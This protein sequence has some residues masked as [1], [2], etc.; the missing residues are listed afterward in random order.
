ME[1]LRDMKCIRPTFIKQI[2][3]A[4]K[5]F[6]HRVLLK[7]RNFLRPLGARK[8]E[9]K[10][11]LHDRHLN[12]KQIIVGIDQLWHM[13]PRDINCGIRGSSMQPSTHI[14]PAEKKNWVYAS[15]TVIDGQ[16]RLK[17]T[18]AAFDRLIFAEPPQITGGQVEVIL[19]NGDAE[20]HRT[21]IVLPHDSQATRIPIR[22]L[23]TSR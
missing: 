14:P 9:H 21:A 8:I 15:L 13:M 11:A 23:G 10:W 12:H 19:K 7:I 17:P 22:L 6:V 3:Y 1:R 20:Q 18:H 16:R 5:M 4:L 2:A